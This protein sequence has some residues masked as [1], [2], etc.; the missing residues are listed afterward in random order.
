MLARVHPATRWFAIAA[1]RPFLGVNGSAG[2]ASSAV[3]RTAKCPEPLCPVGV[4]P[5]PAWC[6]CTTWECFLTPSSLLRA[7]APDRNPPTDFGVTLYDRSLQVVASP[8]WVMAFPDVISAIRVRAPGPLPRG[9]FPMLRPVT[10]SGSISLTISVSGSALQLSPQATSRDECISEL[11]SFLYVRAPA[12]A[13]PAGCSHRSYGPVDTFF[14]PFL[15]CPKT[16]L[17]SGRPDSSAAARPFTPRRSR[18]VTRH[19]PG[20]RYMS[21]SGQLTWR[22]LHPQDRSLV[23]CSLHLPPYSGSPHVRV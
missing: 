14:A 12:L 8:C 22:D 17:F 1:L 20:Y 23:G 16:L 19:D 3:P 18:P 9:V 13:R 10:F 11:Q 15:R 7:H 5:L 6:R 21:E 4:L 2:S